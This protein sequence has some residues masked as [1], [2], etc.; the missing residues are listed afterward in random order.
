MRA[1]QLHKLNVRGETSDFQFA[2]SLKSVK[3]LGSDLIFVT[4]DVQGFG[5]IG[6]SLDVTT[7]IGGGDVDSSYVVV[8][9]A[10]DTDVMATGLGA[11]INAQTDHTAIAVETQV[12]ILKTTAGSVQVITTEVT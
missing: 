10:E 1:S 5:N 12:Q 2:V 3:Q 6:D 11:A 7:D 4:V 8:A 9:A